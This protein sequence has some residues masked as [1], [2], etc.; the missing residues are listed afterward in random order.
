MKGSSLVVWF[1]DQ[2]PILLTGKESIY[3]TDIG[4]DNI[5]FR[6]RFG[7]ILKEKEN[8]AGFNL[9]HAKEYF[10]NE[11]RN[12]EKGEVGQYILDHNLGTRRIHY[13]E[14][15]ETTTGYSVHYRYLPTD[16]YR[17]IIKG[18]KEE[19]EGSMET[20]LR[21]TREELGMNI[22]AEELKKIGNCGGYD[23][24]SVDI[25]KKNYKMFM[26][27]I[28]RRYGNRRGEVFELKFKPL[29]EILP[30]L[31]QYNN[32]SKCAIE[33]FVE[34]V[35]GSTSSSVAPSV[36]RSV[37]PSV[38]RSVAPSV[39]GKLMSIGPSTAK[40][41]GKGVKKSVKKTVK[42]RK[43]SYKKSRRTNKR[44]NKSQ[45]K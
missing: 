26:D 22:P 12:L 37:A 19:G 29:H 40:S 8:Y 5:D 27:T 11:A 3:V 25:K 13:D 9:D 31:N 43:R 6:D 35:L 42:R 15:T 24:Y 4:K 20:I 7:D 30:D 10:S 32:R 36:S 17:G 2:E 39:S 21:E 23:V 44:K 45:K 28:I 14:P 1:E 41:L 38:S 34:K 33:K 18:G 16:H